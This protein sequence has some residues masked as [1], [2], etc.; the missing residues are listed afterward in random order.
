MPIHEKRN[1]SAGPRGLGGQEKMKAN[2]D[3]IERD[4]LIFVGFSNWGPFRVF[5]DRVNES[6]EQL[7]QKPF[8]WQYKKGNRSHRDI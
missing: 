8:R 1:S 2:K 7:I 6:K 3:R 4:V 5:D